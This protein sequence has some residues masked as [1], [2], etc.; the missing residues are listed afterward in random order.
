[1]D[2]AEL[3]ARHGEH[4]E[5]IGVAQVLLHGEGKLRE[6]GERLQVVRMHAVVVE[7]LPVEGRVL[8]G[9]ADRPLHPL[10]LQPGDL[11]ARGVLDGVEALAGG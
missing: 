7:P 2:A 3:L 5:R 1:M 8:V 4:A 10:E 11:V 9:V 6:V